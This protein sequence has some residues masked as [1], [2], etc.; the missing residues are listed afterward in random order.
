M[1]YGTSVRAIVDTN[2]LVSGLLSKS[3]APRTII[4]AIVSGRITPVFS[5]ATLDELRDVLG[6]PRL[7]PYLRRAAVDA[8][9]F[10][11][12]LVQVSEVVQP[13]DCPF[14]IRDPKDRPFLALAATP[15]AP[16]LLVTGDKDFT[17][18]Q[19]GQVPVVTAADLARL[20]E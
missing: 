7:Q 2:V 20:L 3:G 10:L 9:A 4:D 16:D 19:Y 13:V 1:G 12:C 18:T 6:R 11:A 8:D 15:P 5:A 14:P 17:S